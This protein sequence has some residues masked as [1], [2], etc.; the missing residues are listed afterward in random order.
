MPKYKMISLT[1]LIMML[2]SFV[3]ILLYAFLI[4]PNRIVIKRQAVSISTPALGSAL[5]NIKLLH[6]SDLHIRKIGHR[7]RKLISKVNQ[8]DADLI[9]I[10]GDFL[11]EGSNS[12]LCL[13][14]LNSLKAKYGIFGVL[15]N[16]DHSY[17]DAEVL[18]K[19]LRNIGIEVLVNEHRR[20][21]VNG[22]SI[23]LVGVD[24]SYYNLDDMAKAMAGVPLGAPTILLAHSPDIILARGDGLIINL[25]DNNNRSLRG[26]G[27]QDGKRSKSK[28]DVYFAKDGQHTLRIQRR[29][30]GVAIDQIV[31]SPERFL[32][33]QPE[34]KVSKTGIIS[35]AGEIIIEV[36][37]IADKDIHGNWKK[38]S[39]PEASSGAG[40]A[41]MPDQGQQQLVTLVHPEHYFQVQF[42][43]YKNTK[44]HVWVRMKANRNSIRS[45]SVYLQFSDS[46][47][48][49][50]K[51]IYQIQSSVESQDL[52]EIDLILSGHTH[53]GQ[54]RL[55]FIGT[56][57]TQ[58]ALGNGYDQ[59]LF[60]IHGIKLYISRGIGTSI[61]PIRFLSPPEM[62]LF[63][64]Q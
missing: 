60:E 19:E 10:T 52:K 7:E 56:L 57:Q 61:L 17:S 27:W 26:W 32:L 30:D 14:V 45:D 36:T 33:T 20:V 42:N 21:D 8:I 6:L 11:A 2:S 1:I 16:E 31:I 3:F 5:R 4:E 24:S 39:D 25:Y 18:T 28:G 41:D 47:D 9:V 62:A 48:A 22:Q 50:G 59:G 13:D 44:Y 55:P 43:A 12:R 29:E 15:G 38:Y 37:Q 35:H 64:L 53:G 46:V 51:P 63:S 58:S 49:Y 40:I 23:Y 54:V 34:D